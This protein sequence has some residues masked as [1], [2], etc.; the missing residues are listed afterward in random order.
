M[1]FLLSLTLVSFC[2]TACF[3]GDLGER[4]QLDPKYL[5]AGG[6]EALAQTDGGSSAPESEGP[7]RVPLPRPK[8]GCRAP[9]QGEPADAG[10]STSAPTAY[11]KM[12]AR[13]PPRPKSANYWSTASVCGDVTSND[14]AMKSATRHSTEDG[15]PCD[16]GAPCGELH[17]VQKRLQWMRVG[18]CRCLL[19]RWRNDR[20][21]CDDGNTTD[22]SSADCGYDQNC[23][24]CAGDCSTDSRLPGPL[25]R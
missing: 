10:P 14:A 25:R 6:G 13:N 4:P 22:E 21:Y 11:Q 17:R 18:P 12:P 3:L 15:V 20:R 16:Y 23:Q 8:T 9:S 7:M 2:S 1:R 24:F 5:D 19:R